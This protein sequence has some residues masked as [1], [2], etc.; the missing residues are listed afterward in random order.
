MKTMSLY[1]TYD[2]DVLVIGAGGAGLRAAIEAAAQS[3]VGWSANPCWVRLTRL[4]L[5]VVLLQRYQTLIE[6]TGKY[7]SADTM[8]GELCKQLAYGRCMQRSSDRV[9]ERKSEV[10][11]FD[12]TKMA[13]FCKKFWWP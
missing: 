6:I 9:N 10:T 12:R 5:R 7:I 8:R 3:A 4:W 1:D 11:L 13:V 2:C